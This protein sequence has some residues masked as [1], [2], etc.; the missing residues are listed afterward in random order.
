[1]TIELTLQDT[2]LPDFLIEQIQSVAA[3]ARA[4]G[5]Y[6]TIDHVLPSI[7]INDEYHFQEHA[8][9]E[10]LNDVPAEVSAEDWLLWQ[11]QSW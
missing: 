10:L 6:V 7:D 5:Q 1:M 3:A 11:V 4:E 2:T 9:T 8:A